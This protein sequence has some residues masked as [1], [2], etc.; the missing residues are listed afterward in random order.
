[1]PA[2]DSNNNITSQYRQRPPRTTPFASTAVRMA[3]RIGKHC[4]LVC[5]AAALLTA[6]ASRP[7]AAAFDRPVTHAL[8]TTTTTPLSAALSPIESAHP[9][10]SGF[11]VLSN[12]TEALQM[13]IGRAH[14]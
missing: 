5:A 6:C 10:E 12:G 1:M 2:Y 14:V 13:Q 11:R 8:P 3:T 7:P 9:G 4:L